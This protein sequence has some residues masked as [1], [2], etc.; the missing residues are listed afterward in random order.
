ML[1]ALLLRHRVAPVHGGDAQPRVRQQVRLCW[2][3]HTNP[4]GREWWWKMDDAETLVRSAVSEHR[5]MI[6]QMR[7]VP[8][9][10]PE[11]FEEDGPEALRVVGGSPSCTRDWNVRRPPARAPSPVPVLRDAVPGGDREPAADHAAVRLRGRRHAGYAEGHRQTALRR[12]LGASSR[13]RRSES[14]SNLLFR[15][16]SLSRGSSFSSPKQKKGASLSNSDC[17]FDGLSTAARCRHRRRPKIPPFGVRPRR[18][19]NGDHTQAR[20]E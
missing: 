11:R 3:H 18:G 10:I 16:P 15:A 12:L 20:V 2:R 19:I 13:A 9:V 14:A 5:G 8:G 17:S 4:V 6:K 1:Q 7:G